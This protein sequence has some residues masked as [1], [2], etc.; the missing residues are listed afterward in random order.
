MKEA[1]GFVKELDAIAEK[2]SESGS[3]Q[4]LKLKEAV[5]ETL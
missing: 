4:I 3:S 1:E 2:A 5:T